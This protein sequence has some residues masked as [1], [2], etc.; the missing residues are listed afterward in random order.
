[1]VEKIVTDTEERM[2]KSLASFRRE[3]SMIRTGKASTAL[4]D[5]VKVEC[6][7]QVMPLNHVASVSVPEPRLILIQPWDRTIVTSVEKAIHK[8]DLGLV[9]NID[10]GVIRLSVPPLTEERR[11]DLVKLVRKHAEEARVSMRNIRRDTNDVLKKSEKD[12][13]IAEDESHK[14]QDRIQTITDKFVAD[15]DETLA[16]KEKEI[17]EV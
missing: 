17:M 5:G 1:M 4:L 3:L 9:P 13:K 11:R 16:A 15:I 2:K 12:G 10:G 7:G 14:I 8:S 6:Y